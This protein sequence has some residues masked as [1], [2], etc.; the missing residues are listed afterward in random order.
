[1]GSDDWKRLQACRIFKF[2]Q[3]R[4][5]SSSRDPPHHLRLLCWGFPRTLPRRGLEKTEIWSTL[6]R[7][8]VRVSAMASGRIRFQEAL[9]HHHARPVPKVD[10]RVFGE[11]I[12]RAQTCEPRRRAAAQK[13]TQEAPLR[14]EEA[15]RSEAVDGSTQ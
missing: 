2:Q 1:M 11:V 13:A 10:R 9:V 5:R 14:H 7:D 4:R 8:H 12:A 3:H 6:A 15:S